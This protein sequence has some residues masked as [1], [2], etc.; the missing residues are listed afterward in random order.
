MNKTSRL[1]M[2]TLALIVCT[3]VYAKDVKT[4]QEFIKYNDSGEV[5]LR[6]KYTRDAAGK[7]IRYDVHDAEGNLMYSD[8]PYYRN[9]GAIIR[10]DTLAPNGTLM[11]VAVF[12]EATVKV[13]DKDGK[14]LPEFDGSHS[15]FEK[16][17]SNH[18]KQATGVSPASDM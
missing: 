4:D 5:V 6:G 7:V 15:V 10:A 2:G 18:Q 8:I 17:S 1:A 16:E 13:F 14:H 11:R 3:A 9:D 12:F